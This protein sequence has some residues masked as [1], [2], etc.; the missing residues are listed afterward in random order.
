MKPKAKFRIPHSV[1]VKAPGLM[2][3]LY[4]IRELVLELEIPRSTLC[5]WLKAGAPHQRDNRGHI[6]INGEEFAAWVKERRKAQIPRKL[7]EHEG[8]CMRCNQITEL[9][10]EEIRQVSSNLIH[11]IG[12]C[13]I[14]GGKVIRGGRYDRTTKLSESK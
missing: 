1:I 11:K 2:P 10:D 14:C 4:T 6:W 3:M 9:L 8:Y 7:S 12:K 13:S 5:D